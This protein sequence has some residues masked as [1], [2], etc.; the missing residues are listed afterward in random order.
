MRPDP[1]PVS[2]PLEPQEQALW[3]VRLLFALIAL[4]GCCPTDR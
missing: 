2:R 4:Y 1:D 3:C